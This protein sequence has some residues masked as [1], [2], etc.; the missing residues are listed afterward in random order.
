[1][2]DRSSE[3]TSK[4]NVDQTLR[5]T[6]FGL[7]LLAIVVAAIPSLHSKVNAVSTE[8]SAMIAPVPALQG[9]NHD[10][11]VARA[12]LKLDH[13]PEVRTQLGAPSFDRAGFLADQDN[14]IADEFNIPEGLEERVGFWFDI[15]T[16]Y[17]S[18]KKVIHH[19]LYPWIIYK[20]IDVEPIVNA[21]FPRRRWMRNEV[22]N[23]LVKKELAAVR[24]AL[25]SISK[26][27]RASDL[28][29]AR[30]TA[31]EIS[32]RDAL[33]KLGPNVS[34]IARKSLREVR[35]QTGQR[36]FMAEGLQTAPRYMTVME[37]IFKKHR[38]PIELT[39][40]PLVESSFN[41]HAQSKVG[42]MGVWQF[43]ESSGKKQRLIV[44]DVVDER[45]SV[46][47]STHAAANQLK[48]NHMILHRSWPLAVTAWNHGPS[49]VR[50]A[51][52]AA[53][54]KDLPTIIEVYH[55][56]RFGFATENF[57]AEFLAALHTERYSNEIFP[58]L[59]KHA[60]LMV[61]EIV[62]TRKV[63]SDEI[64]KVAAITVDEFIG[65]NPEFAKLIKT[66][67]PLARGYRIHIPSDSRS[68]IEYM[69]SGDAKDKRLVGDNR[70]P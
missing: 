23:N 19:A 63:R 36:D 45:K 11:M 42:A 33:M 5:R 35:V 4:K 10:E 70:R 62:L 27:S 69:M 28:T 16:Q 43:M 17:D 57:Y 47:K 14:R 64:L 50:K 44:N 38:L 48:E 41:K 37:E 20:V 26:K 12:S 18:N 56:K 34:K 6:A 52:R 49:G 59:P 61:Q 46:F 1:M 2:S 39:R 40:L 51:Y 22:A 9:L 3:K 53:K 7:G 31:D 58:G 21:S 68:A 32:V 54:T 13:I 24:K 66:N 29:S 67:K 30:L 60:P 8:T 25:V 15:Y 65:M 55:S